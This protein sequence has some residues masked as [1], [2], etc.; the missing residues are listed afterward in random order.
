MKKS[1]T[2]NPSVTGAHGI[3]WLNYFTLI[4]IKLLADSVVQDYPIFE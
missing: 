2:L 1:M 3:A 4:Q